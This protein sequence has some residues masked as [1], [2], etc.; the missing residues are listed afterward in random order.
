MGLFELLCNI[1]DGD[2]TCKGNRATVSSELMG[3]SN[4]SKR[5]WVCNWK[6]KLSECTDCRQP[7]S[8]SGTAWA[9]TYILMHMCLQCDE[10]RH[11]VAL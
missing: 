9:H 10:H 5:R 7:V 4:G 3:G 8:T 2:K 1:L 11:T 6:T